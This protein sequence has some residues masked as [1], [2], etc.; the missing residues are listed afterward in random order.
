MMAGSVDVDA[1]MEGLFGREEEEEE[2]EGQAQTQSLTQ[3][4]YC[5]HTFCP[6]PFDV[7]WIC[8]YTGHISVG[9]L[10]VRF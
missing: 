4:G 9:L 7:G 3:Q 2:G 1:D 5:S 8:A 6:T 10:G